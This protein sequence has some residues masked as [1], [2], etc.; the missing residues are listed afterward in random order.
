[1]I[2]L[3]ATVVALVVLGGAALVV[4]SVIVFLPRASDAT[5]GRAVLALLGLLLS[6]S[7]PAWADDRVDWRDIRVLKSGTEA[8]GC[9]FRGMAQDDDMEDILKKASKIYGDTVAMKDTMRGKDFVVEVYRCGPKG[10]A[11]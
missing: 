9:E 7:C 10:G 2:E 4:G 1:M 11:R 5:C 8:P 3:A 6:A